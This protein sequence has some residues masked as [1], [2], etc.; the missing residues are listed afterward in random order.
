[1]WSANA[2]YLTAAHNTGY[3]HAIISMC[4]T[5]LSLWVHIRIRAR[6]RVCVC[7]CVC[8]C[9]C[10]CVHA[11]CV[12]MCMCFLHSIFTLSQS[13]FMTSCESYKPISPRLAPGYFVLSTHALSG[14]HLQFKPIPAGTAVY[15]CRKCVQLSY[16]Y[17]HILAATYS[18]IYYSCL[19]TY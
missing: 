13:K 17:N 3:V 12:C 5:R 11:W 2:M 18:L 4:T 10:V 9:V 7:V 16:L 19:H 8:M 6:A 1:M 14:H 15:F